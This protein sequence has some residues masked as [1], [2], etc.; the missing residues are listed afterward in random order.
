MSPG[1]AYRR[2][3]GQQL[4]PPTFPDDGSDVPE[5]Y[6]QP[7]TP[8][9][10][11]T[12]PPP[13]PVAPSPVAAAPPP[14]VE[15][16]GSMSDEV[17]TA[18]PVGPPPVKIAQRPPAVSLKDRLLGRPGV[19]P[20]PVAVATNGAQQLPQA[21]TPRTPG[22]LQRIGAAA[23]GAGAGY[24]NAAGRSH[25]DPQT[26]AA[27]KEGILHPGY[28]AK[29]A[30]YNRTVQQIQQQAEMNSQAVKDATMQENAASLKQQREAKAAE[31]AGKPAADAAALKEKTDIATAART[32]RLWKLQTEGRNVSMAQ[33]PGWDAVQNPDGVTVYLSPSAK[34]VPK[35]LV[36]F[37]PGSK[38]G[39]IIDSRSWDAAAKEY[40]ETLKATKVQDNKPDKIK[41]VSAVR[42]AVSAA[43][44]NPDDPASI[45]PD[46]A[47]KASAILKP[48]SAAGAGVTLTQEAMD[49]WAKFA[50]TTGQLPAL[51]MG[52]SGAKARQDILNRA[53]QVVGGDVATNRATNRS[54]TASLTQ[55]QK[56]RDSVVAFES[57]A[58]ANLD[59]FLKT[60]KPI[61]DS[62]SPLVNQPMR[63]I[64]KTALGSKELAAYDAAR[65]VAINEIAKVTNNP[66]LAGTLS[67]AAR[68]E[69][70]SLIPEQATLGQIYAV[71][72]VLRNDMANRHTELDKGLADIKGRMGG[73][74]TPSGGLP[75]GAGKAIDPATAKRFYDAA[76]G[77]PAKARQ[78]ATQAGWKVQ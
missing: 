27:G 6:P 58:N 64:N 4:I 2:R 52:N 62:G 37:S 39:E 65:R 25:I 43:G 50:G 28:G 54:D 69:V 24:V 63:A 78:M 55:M 42:L 60:A 59:L 17:A 38:E 11:D 47:K 33:L 46:I 20:P 51:G 23:L 19:T 36:E 49:Y 35:E 71:A 13:A 8:T 22:I 57:T 45:T 77:D 73:G 3:P 29:Q 7:L 53:P 15:M 16:P 44:G 48:P 12:P 18:P 76:G 67:D 32:D 72:N 66:T 31:L 9:G 21:P 1:F 68:K 40:R 34:K 74:A 14:P 5:L 61:V 30:A 70:E 56:M 10:A 26:I 75:Q 41:D